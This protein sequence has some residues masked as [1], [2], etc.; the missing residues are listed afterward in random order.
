VRQKPYYGQTYI[1]RFLESESSLRNEGREFRMSPWVT[2]MLNEDSER[3][4]IYRNQ[5]NQC[6]EL[7]YR[8]GIVDN[9]LRG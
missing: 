1:E 9:D 4:R 8:K 7:A 6:L 5:L 3:A 2:L